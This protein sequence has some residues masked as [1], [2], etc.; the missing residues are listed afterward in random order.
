MV[1]AHLDGTEYLLL[2]YGF[3]FSRVFSGELLT[4]ALQI[5]EEH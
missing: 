5:T 4:L 1:R 2:Q 3:I